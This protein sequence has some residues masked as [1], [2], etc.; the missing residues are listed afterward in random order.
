MQTKIYV[1]EE[2]DKFYERHCRSFI[3]DY[4]MTLFPKQALSKF[5]IAE[6]GI[7]SGSNLILLM[8]YARS[9]HGYDG[10]K[11]AIE[12]FKASFSGSMHEKKCFAKQVNLCDK[13][14]TP[15]KYDLAIMGFFA[16][17]ASDEELFVF[18]ENLLNCM[19]K[20]GYVFIEDFLV[21]ENK[22]KTDSRN[23]NIRIFKR[24]IA[25][26]LNSSIGKPLV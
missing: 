7:G 8:N 4:I 25:F 11:K 6:F 5:D 16:Y 26:W 12:H 15:I 9:I 13:F 18:K 19:V 2:A 1:N 21:R 10:S 24:N 3:V 17:Y 22:I 20:G 23:N 14:T